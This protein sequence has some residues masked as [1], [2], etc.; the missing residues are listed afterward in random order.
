MRRVF[1]ALGKYQYLGA[2]GQEPKKQYGESEMKTLVSNTS[3]DLER[4]PELATSVALPASRKRQ[5]VAGAF[6]L[7]GIGVCAIYLTF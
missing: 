7:L 6:C 2:K 5:D 1:G 4:L 3:I